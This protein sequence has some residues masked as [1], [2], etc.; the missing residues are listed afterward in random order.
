MESA[1][2][3]IS[4]S[5]TRRRRSR[6]ERGSGG[7]E[8]ARLKKRRRQPQPFPPS[9]AQER[10]AQLT[11]RDGS[12]AFLDRCPCRETSIQVGSEM[13]LSSFSKNF[14]FGCDSASP[15]TPRHLNDIYIYIYIHTS[16]AM[17]ATPCTP[18]MLNTYTG[19]RAG[20]PRHAT[21]APSRRGP[22]ARSRS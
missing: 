20:N 2:Q 1:C 12:I 5:R 3:S 9:P 13:T 7:G 8:R 14:P 11:F 21:R 10:P 16:R 19:N 18:N 4:S 17:Y 15:R 22:P 6:L